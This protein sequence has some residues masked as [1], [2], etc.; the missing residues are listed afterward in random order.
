MYAVAQSVANGGVGDSQELDAIDLSKHAIIG[1]LGSVL[2]GGKFENG[3]ITG[4]FGYL[5]NEAAR[6]FQQ[7]L[8]FRTVEGG[9]GD[10]SWRVKWQ[11]AGPSEDGGWIVQQVDMTTTIDGTITPTQTKWEA[12]SVLPGH[13]SAD[14]TN[15]EGY[16]DDFLFKNVASSAQISTTVNGSARFYEGLTL[17]DSFHR[18]SYG[19]LSGNLYSSSVDPHIPLTNATGPVLR[20]DTYVNPHW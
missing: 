4:A 8:S 14:Q 13:E 2:G 9:P 6:D 3:A 10:I 15:N 19:T 11:L 7:S 20:T 5:F 1:G 17:P 18:G 12:W 16:D